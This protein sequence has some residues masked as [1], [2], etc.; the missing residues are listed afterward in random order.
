[1][2]EDSRRTMQLGDDDAFGPVDD[3]RPVLGHQRDVAEEDLFF[4]DVVDRPL[5]GFRIPVPDGQPDLY[6]QGYGVRLAALLA[7][8]HVVFDLQV[9][10]IPAV[11]ADGTVPRVFD[12]LQLAATARPPA[13]RV[14]EKVQLAVV[15]KVLDGEDRT[16]YGLEGRSPRDPAAAGP[17]EGI[18]R[19]TDAG[20]RSAW[21]EESTHGCARSRAAFSSE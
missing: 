8:L 9:D 11:V 16:E 10:P 20:P 12:A 15:A 6:L 5:I 1:M 7:L 3:E 19:R 21:A 4:L 18:G 14:L 2:E 17:S 13:Y